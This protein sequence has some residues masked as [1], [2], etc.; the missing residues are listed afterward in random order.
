MTTTTHHDHGGEP[1]KD[2]TTGEGL[3]ALLNRLHEAGEP[4]PT[5]SIYACYAP[6]PGALRIIHENENERIRLQLSPGIS[7]CTAIKFYLKNQY[8]MIQRTVS[9]VII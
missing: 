2:F 8:I 3:R 7:C 1:V 5:N 9:Y 6:I 4:P